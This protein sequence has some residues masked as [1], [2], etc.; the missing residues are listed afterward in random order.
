M[1]RSVFKFLFRFVFWNCAIFGFTIISFIFLF[2]YTGFGPFSSTPKPLSQDSVLTL[3]LN[4]PYVEHTDSSGLESLMLGKN[5]SLYDLTL[6]LYKGAQDPKIKGLLLRIETPLLGM[7]QI[8]E[9]RDALLAFKKSGKPSWCYTDT[10]GELSSGT[11]FYYLATAC[12]EIWIQPLGALNLTGL[13]VEVPFAKEALEK[14]ALKPELIQRKEYKS[15]VEIYTQSDFSE[16]SREAHQAVLDSILSQLVEGIAKERNIP[17]DQVHQLIAN[18]PYLG[19]KAKAAKLIDYIASYQE[20]KPAIQEKLG[21]SIGF[22]NPGSYLDTFPQE[23]KGNK[24][25]LLFGSGIIQRDGGES[26]FGGN[27]IG[28][29]ATYKAFQSAI[30]DPDVKAIVYRVNSQGGSPIAS[31][32]IYTIIQY[33]SERSK[34][35]VIISMSDAAASGGYWISIAGSKIVAQPATLTGSIGVFGGKIVLSGLYEKL[36]LKWGH[37]STNEN[38]TIW[39]TSESYTPNQW[40]KVNEWID[41]IYEAFTDRVAKARKLTPLQVE[42]VARGRVWTGEQALALGLVDQL[43]GLQMA[44]ELARKEA[45]LT[46]DTPVVIYP[47]PLT[48]METLAKLFEDKE[49]N[50]FLDTGVFGSLFHFFM[51]IHTVISF[52]FSSEEILYSPLLKIK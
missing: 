4:G 29:K 18:G 32:T 33:A 8:Q 48:F 28:A 12:D 50:T 3:T 1:I 24:I 51:R 15:F 9:L 26:S 27:I 38:A 5:A 25:A 34:K 13:N 41:Q 52:F 20:L 39:S 6:A 17:T 21:K 35:P 45:N 36:G 16:T 19:E 31:E 11:S 23:K 7:A 40:M 2:L 44:F 49:E 22:V 43:G 30:S 42:K 46:P 14:L 10:F 47:Q 37:I